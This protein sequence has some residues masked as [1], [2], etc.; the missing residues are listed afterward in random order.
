MSE[1]TQT[2]ATPSNPGSIVV[3][4]DY[5]ETGDTA[6]RT[7]LN[8]AGQQH[9]L[10]VVQHVSDRIKVMYLG[11]VV[12]QGTSDELYAHPHHPYS[13]SLLSAVPIADPKLARLRQHVVLEGDVPSPLNPPEACRFHPRCPRAQPRCSTEEPTLPPTERGWACHYPVARWPLAD[14]RD[15]AVPEE[16]VAADA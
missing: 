7:A 3:A 2:P 16:P 10:H 13:A 9:D 8:M 11:K 1:E 14:P 12:E 6:M 4:I 15:I 5:S